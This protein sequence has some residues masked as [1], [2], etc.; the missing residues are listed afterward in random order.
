MPIDLSKET[1]VSLAEA[2]KRLPRRRG[3]R[4]VHVSCLYRWTQVGL[5][6]VILESIQIGGT[7]CTSIEALSRFFEVLSSGPTE[8][9]PIRSLARRKRAAE[10]AERALLAEGA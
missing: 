4:K 10:A 1:L 2:A 6:G 8:S 5:K 3:G 7:R 9:P